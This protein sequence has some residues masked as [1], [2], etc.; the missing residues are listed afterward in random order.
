LK[1]R[2]VG[3]RFL[4]VAGGAIALCLVTFVATRLSLLFC[5]VAIGRRARW[6]ASWGDTRRHFWRIVISHFLTG[7][8]LQAC[9]VCLFVVT[10]SSA[11]NQQA[12]PYLFAV[13]LALFHSA[14][15]ILGSTCSSC[16]LYQRLARALL[17][18]A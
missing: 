10:R 7:L 5:H 3:T 18:P 12:L 1:I 9:V 4:L 2:F 17:E 8:P 6:R 16:W 14:A 11:I 15:L 13:G